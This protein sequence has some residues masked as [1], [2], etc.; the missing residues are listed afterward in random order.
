[1]TIPE[2]ASQ[3]AGSGV[4]AVFGVLG[5]GESWVLQGELKKMGI[6]FFGAAHEAS[7]AVMAGTFSMVSGNLGA[8]LCIKGP[9]LANM[10]PGVAFCNWEKFPLVVVSEAYSDGS[11]PSRTH[12]RLDHRLHL[13]GLCR[14]AGS[15]ATSPGAMEALLAKARGTP[16]GPVFIELAQRHPPLPDASSIPARR[17]ANLP[18]AV[19]E[20]LRQAMRP[21]LVVGASVIKTEWSRKLAALRVPIFTTAAAKGV[22]HEASPYAAG[23]FTGTGGGL[24]P[25]SCLVDECDLIVG[26]ELSNLE[27]VRPV[28]FAAE[29]VLLTAADDHKTSEGFGAGTVL[30]NLDSDGFGE[31]LSLLQTKEWGRGKIAGI[32][33]RMREAL[34]ASDWLPSHVFEHLSNLDAPLLLVPDTGSFCTVAEHMYLASEDHGYLGGSCSRFMGMGIPMS[35]GA[36]IAAPGLPVFCAVGDGGMHNYP[37]EIKLA[38]KEKLPVCFLFCRDGRYG[39]MADG[40]KKSGQD[41]A[42]ISMFAPSWAGVADAMG[43]P[44]AIVQSLKEFQR[45]LDGWQREGPLFLE[46]PFN[47]DEYA[48][49]TNGVR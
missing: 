15:L 40:G 20:R 37:T 39:C 24:T 35:L 18:E 10:F 29:V 41:L 7:A 33:G 42:A 3:L 48:T 45:Q 14:D 23:V 32:L 46:L 38:V 25:E 31:V 2:L 26:M 16:P 43:C 6:P 22:L 28:T 13:T 47:P 44:A 27:V 11:S 9:G 1:M 19:R 49:M 5:S 4:R 30:G 21:I 12:K 34:K 8:A 36:A 17:S